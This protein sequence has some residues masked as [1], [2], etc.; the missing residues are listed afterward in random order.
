[1]LTRLDLSNAARLWVLLAIVVMLIGTTACA[2]R[3][4]SPD[5][6]VGTYRLRGG[7]Y[8]DLLI[9]QPGGHYEHRYSRAD[10]TAVVDSGTWEFLD[11][12]GPSVVFADFYAYWGH[13]KFPGA[14]LG[15]GYWPAQV[16]R[17]LGGSTRIPVNDDLGLVY[18]RED[19]DSH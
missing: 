6:V 9:V 16:E 15:R 4:D 11:V 18:L 3:L 17:T 13:E 8:A 7:G 14:P 1:M 10:G 19:A 12:E 5:E 2:E